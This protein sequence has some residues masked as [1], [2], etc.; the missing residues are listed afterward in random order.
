MKFLNVLSRQF[1][2]LAGGLKSGAKARKISAQAHG[3]RVRDEH[4]NMLVE[5]AISMPVLLLMFTGIFD[6]GIAYNNQLTLIQAV[7]SGAQ[8]LQSIRTSTTNPCADTLT[9]IENAAPNLT[10]GNISLA[11][12]LNGTKY[13]SS[14]TP[15]TSLSCSGAQTNLAEQEPVTVQATYPCSLPIVFT[16]G[17]TWIST[18]QLS[19]TV[20]EYEY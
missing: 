10:A 12:N 13:P 19:A 16:R 11:L 2:P 3:R 17:V 8:Y 18:C 6:F 9:A 7:G 4:G 15:A 1:V 14:G 5:I 20:T